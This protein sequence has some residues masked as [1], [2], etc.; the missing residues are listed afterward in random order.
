MHEI[1]KKFE[2]IQKDVSQRS[3]VLYEDV[4]KAVNSTESVQP[5]TPPVQESVLEG[6][7]K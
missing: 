1:S 3:K 5:E 4:K 6:S 2:A 7:S